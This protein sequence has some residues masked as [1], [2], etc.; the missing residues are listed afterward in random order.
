MPSGDDL[1]QRVEA[2]EQNVAKWDSL[3]DSYVGNTIDQLSK[4]VDTIEERT[5]YLQRYAVSIELNLNLL[6][7]LR[8]LI[9]KTR[10]KDPVIQQSADIAVTELR[11][12]AAQLQQQLWEGAGFEQAKEKWLVGSRATLEKY[13]FGDFY[14]EAEKHDLLD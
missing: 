3:F 5:T 8:Y 9:D 10:I 2:L 6:W 4:Q 7:A 12:I 11:E 14:G 13:G 1:L